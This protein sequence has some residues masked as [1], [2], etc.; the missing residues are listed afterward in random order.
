M[1]NELQTVLQDD[2]LPLAERLRRLNAW[3]D[4]C[5]HPTAADRDVLLSALKHPAAALRWVVLRAL[6]QCFGTTPTVKTAVVA[7]LADDDPEVRVAALKIVTE[8]FAADDQVLAAVGRLM[9]HTDDETRTTAMFRLG[10]TGTPTAYH[11]LLNHLQATQ[12]KSLEEQ[13]WLLRA[14]NA[15]ADKVDIR[16]AL[17]DVVKL[18]QGLPHPNTEAARDLGIEAQGITHSLLLQALHIVERYHDAR[19]AIQQVLAVGL[20][21]DGA[22]LVAEHC[23]ALRDQLMVEVGVPVGESVVTERNPTPMTNPF[24]ET[25]TFPAIEDDE[26]D[27]DSLPFYAP[28]DPQRTQSSIEEVASLEVAQ[29]R[30]WIKITLDK[31]DTESVPM[32][33]GY[34][35]HHSAAVQ[36]AAINA[37]GEIKDGRARLVLQELSRDQSPALRKLAQIALAKLG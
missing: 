1:K 3:I 26:N 15:V 19:E 36:I 22:P 23:R 29:I 14:L 9:H 21:Y 30:A 20:R 12:Y 27:T 35:T 31:K 16:D 17:P 33:I 34:A 10:K 4:H 24:L 5:T 25:G 2:T 28:P 6:D 13:F 18:V 7:T 37:L 8:R 11:L 32:L